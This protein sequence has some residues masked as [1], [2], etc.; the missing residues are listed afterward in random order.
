VKEAA[1]RQKLMPYIVDFINRK[2][3]MD[4]LDAATVEVW[5]RAVHEIWWVL[6]QWAKR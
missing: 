6:W 2:Q 4:R 3:A 5:L 1:A